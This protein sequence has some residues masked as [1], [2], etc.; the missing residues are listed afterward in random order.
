MANTSCMLGITDNTKQKLIVTSDED[1]IMYMISS[2]KSNNDHITSIQKIEGG[3]KDYYMAIYTKKTS[4]EYNT[5]PI[6]NTIIL[7]G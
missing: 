4:L 2:E 3:T 1:E 5:L 6:Y 7:K